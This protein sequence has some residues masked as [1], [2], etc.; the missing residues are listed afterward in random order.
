M[1]EMVVTEATGSLAVV[2]SAKEARPD[3]A[4][5]EVQQ[6]E[7]EMVELEDRAGTAEALW[8]PYQPVVLA[9]RPRTQ[10]AVAGWVVAE[11]SGPQVVLAEY[12]GAPEQEPLLVVKSEPQGSRMSAEMEERPVRVAMSELM[13]KLV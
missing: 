5:L 1:E 10:A 11:A 8:C 12:Q 13:D 6:E 2:A 3:A 9:R 7:E 4:V